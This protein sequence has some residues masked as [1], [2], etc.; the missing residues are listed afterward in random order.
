MSTPTPP[1]EQA[2]FEAAI[3][4]NP[5]EATHHLAYADW[6]DENGHEDEAAFRRAMGKLVD[7][8]NINPQL[9]PKPRRNETSTLRVKLP[10]VAH[11]EAIP[12]EMRPGDESRWKVRTGGEDRDS[13][14]N[15]SGK[16]YL[17]LDPTSW[18]FDYLHGKPAMRW[19]TYR[20]MESAFRTAFLARRKQNPEHFARSLSAALRK[21][22]S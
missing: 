6:L 21:S 8:V 14:F 2:A 5:L 15:T 22:Q 12:D 9:D 18:A 11:H 13:F 4:Q 19:G 20:N 17:P 7:K 1:P 10:W 16:G 3:D